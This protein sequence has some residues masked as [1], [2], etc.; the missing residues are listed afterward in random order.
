VGK[1]RTSSKYRNQFTMDQIKLMST[2]ELCNHISRYRSMIDE[3]NRRDEDPT[4]YEREFCYLEQERLNRE[5]NK[6]NKR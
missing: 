5:R 3:A 1:N 4:Q 6:Q 2:S